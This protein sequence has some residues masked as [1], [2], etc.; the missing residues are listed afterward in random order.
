MALANPVDKTEEKMKLYQKGLAALEA[1]DALRKKENVVRVIAIAWAAVAAHEL[2]DQQ[3]RDQY[4]ISFQAAGT[5]IRAVG[6]RVLLFFCPITKNLVSFEELSKNI[7]Q[8][9]S[10]E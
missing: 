5:E 2:A 4:C 10:I 8:K 7:K 9:T 6:H 3:K 1:S